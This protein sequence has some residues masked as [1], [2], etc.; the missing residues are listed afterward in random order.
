MVSDIYIKQISAIRHTHK[1]TQMQWVSIGKFSV[2][3]RVSG[4]LSD[5]STIP[6][7]SNESDDD[8]DDD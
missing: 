5:I 7:H 2:F 6:H 3:R 8:D 1:N 4:A